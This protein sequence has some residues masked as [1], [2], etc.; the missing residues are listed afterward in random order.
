MPIL[1]PTYSRYRFDDEVPGLCQ[2]PASG[3]CY[4]NLQAP[5]VPALLLFPSP[6][7]VVSDPTRWPPTGSLS[8]LIQSD[9]FCFIIA[10]SS[11]VGE[12]VERLNSAGY[13]QWP[14]L[15]L[16]FFFPFFLFLSFRILTLRS[17]RARR[18]IFWLDMFRRAS[19]IS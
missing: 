15:P 13:C 6:C 1:H 9:T 2:S 3:A 12:G 17:R 19:S 8:P 16:L 14:G 18:G 7:S 11:N 10:V 4:P 5:P